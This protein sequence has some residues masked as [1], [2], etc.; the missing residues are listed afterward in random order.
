MPL[1]KDA[2]DD[3]AKIFIW[4]YEGETML[5][6]QLLNEDERERYKDYPPRKLLEVLMVRK[7]LA[8]KLPGA[9]IVYSENGEPFLNPKTA[10]ISISHSFPFAAVAFSERKIGID[11]ERFQDK[12]TRVK[13][14]FIEKSEQ[15]FIPEDQ[16]VEYLTIIWSVKESLYKLHHSKH[17]SLKQHYTVFPF[18]RNESSAIKCSVHDG[19]TVEEFSARAIFFEDFVFTAV[20]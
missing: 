1:Y 19:E 3:C 18:E 8:E 10:E 7:I 6:E 15:D 2:S 11:I 4:K 12:I 5:P 17:W 16:S 9:R 20:Q 14:K 13:D